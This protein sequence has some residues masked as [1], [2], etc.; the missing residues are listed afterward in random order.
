MGTRCRRMNEPE[1]MAIYI[2]ERPVEL[3]PDKLA[4]LFLGAS[5]GGIDRFFMQVRRKL[6]LMERPIGTS[7]NMRRIWSGYSPY[8]PR[9][10]QKLLDIYRVYYNYVKIGQ[11]KQ[12]PAMR[13]GL[14]RSPIKMEDIIYYS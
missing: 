13:L 5:L 10:I 8:N 4:N 12:T 7:S 6:S 3:S 2:T 9:I 14:A 1:K 11:D